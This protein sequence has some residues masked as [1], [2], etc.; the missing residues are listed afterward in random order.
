[1]S[2]W[3]PGGTVTDSRSIDISPDAAVGVYEIKVG[4]YDPSTADSAAAGGVDLARTGLDPCQPGDCLDGSGRV[5]GFRERF[6]MA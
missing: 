1:M 6:R 5:S 4:V 3:Q 2:S